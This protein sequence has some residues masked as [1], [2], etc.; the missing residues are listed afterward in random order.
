L[1]KLTL[2]Q[3]ANKPRQ[4]HIGVNLYKTKQRLIDFRNEIEAYE[5]KIRCEFDHTRLQIES[6]F[7]Q[8][9]KQIDCM[10]QF[11]LSQL[12][13]Y[14]SD[15]N[16]NLKLVSSSI[17]NNMRQF[18]DNNASYLMYLLQNYELVNWQMIES[19]EKYIDENL[20]NIAIMLR[21]K[22]SMNLV[23]PNRKTAVD[24][25]HISLGTLKTRPLNSQIESKPANTK[26]QFSD[27]FSIDSILQNN[28]NSLYFQNSFKLKSMHELMNQQT[29]QE[30]YLLF[31]ESLNNNYKFK[32]YD[33]GGKCIKE[34]F[35][36]KS[37]QEIC[38]LNITADTIKSTTSQIIICYKLINSMSIQLSC[39]NSSLEQE[40]SKELR[41]IDCTMYAPFDLYVDTNRVYL[42]CQSMISFDFK[43]YVLNAKFDLMNSFD[44][45]YESGSG[46]GSMCLQNAIQCN[47]QFTKLFVKD[48]FIFIKKLTF[49]LKENQQKC[50]TSI[51]ILD[52]V[53]GTLVHKKSSQF[54]FDQFAI[55]SDDD[56]DSA[57]DSMECREKLV[58]DFQEKSF[59]ILFLK[60]KKFFVYDLNQDKLLYSCYFHNN[61]QFVSNLFCMN[62][63]GEICSLVLN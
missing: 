36:A 58:Q 10:Q 31:Y 45:C 51:F 13:E 44:L 27:D 6:N 49:E 48:N 7:K 59:R 33:Q 39:V 4:N 24:K 43:I 40:F 29:G 56:N 38:G 21:A 46:N 42:L 41:F 30:N 25:S 5:T 50:F 55:V 20:R 3:S 8:K 14:E 22:K 12:D 63:Q 26:K 47:K 37:S 52:S 17:E 11:Y 53:Y 9:T 54:L 18:C 2:N 19:Y 34:E 1:N 57:Y 35:I 15:L 61:D 16:E 28:K 23:Q 32:M 62:R 60:D